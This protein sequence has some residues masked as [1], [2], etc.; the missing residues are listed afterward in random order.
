MGKIWNVVSE[1]MFYNTG[2]GTFIWVLSNRKAPER[3]GKIQLIDATRMKSPLRKNL[4]KKNC[5]F[6]PEIRRRILALY[7]EMAEGE[8][9]RVFPNEEFGYHSA[10]EWFAFLK[11][12]KREVEQPIQVK[13]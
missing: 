6:S 10:Q 7:L 13:Y 5:E 9:S 4:G 12:W 2:I 11:E 1:N 3:R 8:C